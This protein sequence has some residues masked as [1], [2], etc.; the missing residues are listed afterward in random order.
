LKV[1]FIGGTGIISSACTDLCV[2]KG[3]DVTLLN[4][5]LT[6]RPIPKDVRIIRADIRNPEQIKSILSNEKFDVVVDWIAYSQDHVEKDFEIFKEKTSQ[7]IFISS[8][9]TY[10]K[11]PD[12]L[13]IKE[14]EPLI[15][16]HWEYS[17]NK[18]KCEEYLLQVFNDYE[19]PVTIVRPSHTY[20]RTK[21][22]LSG[23]Y[24]ALNRIREGKKVIIHGDGTSL[25]TLTHHQ[26]FARGFVGLLGNSKTIGEA[27]HI[28]SDEVLT[29]NQICETFS[30]TVGMPANIIHI[31]SDFIFSYDKEWGEGLLGDKA[32][33]MIFDNRKIKNINPDFQIKI[34]FKEGAKEIVTWYDENPD[35]KVIDQAWES[36]MDEI[37]ERYESFSGR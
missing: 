3:I 29:W 24:T 4:R 34:P 25:W 13:P 15:N 23:G 12:S 37:I 10:Q 22:A 26:D 1:L 36:K 7:Y 19:F 30:D 21:I 32:H 18:I 27:Y 8:A 9:S 31:P 14:T 16:P 17:R 2:E 6:D 28:T 33:C 35:R 11:P 5:G 20:D